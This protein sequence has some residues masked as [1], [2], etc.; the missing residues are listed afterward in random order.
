MQS[1]ALGISEKTRL[2]NIMVDAVKNMAIK[3]GFQ[4][5]MTEAFLNELDM[6][7]RCFN[8]GLSGVGSCAVI[9]ILHSFE[10]RVNHPEL[11][12]NH[13]TQTTSL[14]GEALLGS[15]IVGAKLTED[16]AFWLE[17]FLPYTLE[18]GI[19]LKDLKKIEQEHMRA[20]DFNVTIPVGELKNRFFQLLGYVNQNDI[21]FFENVFKQT[22]PNK[23][24][25]PNGLPQDG[26]YEHS[27]G[28]HGFYQLYSKQLQKRVVKKSVEK[29]AADDALVQSNTSSSF[30]TAP[31]KDKK[32]H[33]SMPVAYEPVWTSVATDY[34]MSRRAKK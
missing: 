34:L 21:P 4:I 28:E 1:H 18:L 33:S 26:F 20:L 8:D 14:L 3:N 24:A 9:H 12:C 11:F 5:H 16:D 29:Y 19:G 7:K 27:P 30:F 2:S 6:L 23:K 25:T 15:L 31:K 13:V 22:N 10:K 17:D 32:R